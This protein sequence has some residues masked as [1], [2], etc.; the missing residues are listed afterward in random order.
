[1][2]RIPF[3]VKYFEN[4]LVFGADGDVFAYYELQP[5]N[6]DYRSLDDQLSLHGNLEAFYWNIHADTHALVVP[7]HQSLEEHERAMVSRLSGPLLEAGKR[8]IHTAIEHLKGRDI[9]QH[10]FFIGV[11]LK[12]ASVKGLSL[13]KEIRYLWKDFIRYMQNASGTDMTEIFEE[14][15]RA[16]QVQEEMIYSRIN[17]FLRARRLDRKS[18]V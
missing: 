3:P 14:E 2:A 4:N 11:K 6:Y 1:M 17:G 5:F 13:F 18:V 7:E 16:Y 15:I 9:H 8:H 12:P 10:R